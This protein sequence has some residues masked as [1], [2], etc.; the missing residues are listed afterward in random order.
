MSQTMKTCNH[1]GVE[2]IRGENIA[3]SQFDK[4]NFKC[5]PCKSEEQRAYRKTADGRASVKRDNSGDKKRVRSNRYCHSEK[6]K[7]TRSKYDE[8]WRKSDSGL[9]SARKTYHA[10]TK[11]SIRYK[12]RRK[13]Y[14]QTES[15]KISSKKSQRK[16]VETGYNKYKVAKRRAVILRATPLWSEDLAIKR[17]YKNCPEGYEVD[18]IEPLQGKDVSGL[19]V[20]ANLQY[21]TISE[22]RSKSNRRE[23]A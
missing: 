9:A 21:L 13:K 5:S 16:L 11:H 6:G 3:P 1:C 22:N 15:Y 14:F 8:Q 2:L 19:H 18:H 7:E 4:S 23:E 17:F 10:K 12:E 20:L